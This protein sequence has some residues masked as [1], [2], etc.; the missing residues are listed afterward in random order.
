MTIIMKEYNQEQVEKLKQLISVSS[1]ETDEINIVNQPY[2]YAYSAFHQNEMIGLIVAWKS[3]FHPHC[4]YF[5]VIHHP[6]YTNLVDELITEMEENLHEDEYPLQTVVMENTYLDRYYATNSYQV[7][8]KTYLPSVLVSLCHAEGIELPEN[9]LIMS[10]DGISTNP[11]LVQK[12]INLVKSVYEQTHLINP[13]A[14]LELATW[15]KMIF[16]EDTIMLGSYVCLD[17]KGDDIVA[18][19]LLHESDKPKTIELGWCGSSCCGEMKTVTQLVNSICK[20]AW[21]FLIRRRI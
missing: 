14:E 11:N 17:E 8:R 5:R 16:A 9:R 15:R 18:F 4:T 10:L 2:K 7:A 3:S 21:I 13:V 1:L 20:K 19:S 12:L 6:E